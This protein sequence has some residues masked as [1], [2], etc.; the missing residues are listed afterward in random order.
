VNDRGPFGA[1]LPNGRYVVK[2]SP[3]EP[4]RWRG[5]LDVSVA[6]ARELGT[7]GKGLEKVEIR[8][9]PV[10]EGIAVAQRRRERQRSK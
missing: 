9:W 4:G 10:S 2:T 1:K 7:H 6:A 5:V 8:Y 3:S